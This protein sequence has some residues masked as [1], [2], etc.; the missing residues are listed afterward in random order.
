MLSTSCVMDDDN[1]GR[2]CRGRE[3]SF[4]REDMQ[5]HVAASRRCYRVSFGTVADANRNFKSFYRM[6][7]IIKIRFSLAF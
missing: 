5:L 1:F 7:A 4:Y 2:T 3:N 6:L